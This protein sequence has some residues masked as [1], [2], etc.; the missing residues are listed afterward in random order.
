MNLF[1]APGE[2]DAIEEAEGSAARKVAMPSA[3]DLVRGK[4]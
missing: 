3:E 1:L 4:V 2:G